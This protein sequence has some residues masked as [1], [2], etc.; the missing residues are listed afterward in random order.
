MEARAIVDREVE[1]EIDGGLGFARNSRRPEA[2]SAYDFMYARTYP[3][4][5]ARS[6]DSPIVDSP[7]V[8]SPGGNLSGTQS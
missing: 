1:T 8:E 6:V 4:L 5:P 2:A 7:S 3:G